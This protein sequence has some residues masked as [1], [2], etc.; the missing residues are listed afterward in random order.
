MV[1]NGKRQETVAA[2]V[3]RHARQLPAPPVVES[4]A[5]LRSW[6]VERLIAV[7]EERRLTHIT[8]KYIRM[9]V[10]KDERLRPFLT[11][12]LPK[13][14][15]Q[16][17]S[18]S[19]SRSEWVKPGVPPLP[20]PAQL[21][22]LSARTFRHVIRQPLNTVARVLVNLLLSFFVGILF[23][24]TGY[25]QQSI[26]ARVG[27]LFFMT[28]I[29]AFI[30]VVAAVLTFTEERA[31]FLREKMKH[32]Y[33]TSAYFLGRTAVDIGMQTGL[34]ILFGLPAYWMVGLQNDFGKFVQFSICLVMVGQS[35]QS[36]AL[37]LG[38]LIPYRTVALMLSPLVMVPF[39]MTTGFFVTMKSIPGWLKWLCAISPQRY[40]FESLMDIEFSGLKLKCRLE[41]MITVPLDNG[42]LQRYCPL[43]RGEDVTELFGLERGTYAYNMIMVFV[44]TVVVRLVAYG[45]LRWSAYYHM[46]SS[47][48]G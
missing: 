33:G 6:Q 7:R 17:S 14:R 40:V 3:R 31:L 35:S 8:E 16:G 34:S 12:Y 48:G 10:R 28:S 20:F 36:Y 45:C 42:Q 5:H 24:Q 29:Q 27:F 13:M 30:T 19:D 22:E 44:L 21:K 39:M 18:N 11:N 38:A 43:E 26:Y 4:F 9:P 32:I 47:G 46:R 15:A 25:M 2:R 41:E 1:I 23:L 37:I